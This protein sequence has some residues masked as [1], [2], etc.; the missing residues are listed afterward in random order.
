VAQFRNTADII[1]E[2]LQ[3]SGEPTNGNSPFQSIA[4]TY[5]NKVHHAIVGGGNI[6]NINVDEPWVWARSHAPIVVELQPA[7]TSGYATVLAG[8]TNISFSVAPS[9][10][11]EGWH[12]QLNGMSTVYKITQHTAAGNTAQIDSSFVDTTGVFTFRAFLLDY[13]IFPAYLYVDN[14]NDRFDF[15][16]GGTAATVLSAQVPHGSYTPTLLASALPALLTSTGTAS[17][18]G[19]YDTVANTFNLS[20]SVVWSMLGAT[21]PSTKRSA[22]HTLGFDTLDATGAQT[23]TSTYQPNQVARLIEPFKMFMTNWTK[24]HFCYSTDPIRMQEDYPVSR[25][26][27][28]FP[29]RFCRISEDRNGI[30]WV[31]FNAYPKQVTKLQIDWIPQPRDLQNNT[32]SS[33]RIPRGDIDVLIHGAS[34]FV[35]L[36]KEDSKYSSMVELTKTHLEAMKK[37]NHSLLFRTGQEFGQ[38]VPRSDLNREVRHL[39]YG[40]T[41]SGSTAAATTAQTV[42]AMITSILGFGSFQTASTVASVTASVLPNNMTLFALIVKHSRSFTGAGI[43]GVSLNVGTLGNPTQFI[44]GFNVAQ[45]TAASA[46]DS[47]LVLYFPAV[48]TP[49]VAQMVSTGAN[50]S[51]LAQGS[52]TFYFQ[53]T[54]TQ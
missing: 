49:I 48:A 2:I 17:Y 19:S 38:I 30:I 31:R 13:P 10:S 21:G 41:V 51:A 34:A 32:A 18:T 9:I 12:F 42:Q 47:A 4:L 50:L 29:D 22:L 15:L 52:V 45:T 26:V 23:Y 40:Y 54:I 35:L 27:E 37:K 5:A 14:T 3:K 28:R 7:Y 33:V 1:S 25:I 43:T 8:S 39:N 53:E 11:L 6:F 24:D 46:Q 36:D 20:S 16:E 44:N